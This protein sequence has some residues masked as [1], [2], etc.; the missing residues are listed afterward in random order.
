MLSDDFFFFFSFL[1]TWRSLKNQFLVLCLLHI[2]ICTGTVAPHSPPSG[3]L[4]SVCPGA[5]GWEVSALPRY[6]QSCAHPS[7]G[8]AGRALD[9]QHPFPSVLSLLS[10]LQLKPLSYSFNLEVFLT[11]GVSAFLLNLFLLQSAG[12]FCH[13]NELSLSF[14][15]LSIPCAFFYLS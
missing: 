9:L 3:Q 7:P 10:V 1:F 6:S 14:F 2:I 12:A 15:F 13:F 4:P 8:A 11:N 5:T